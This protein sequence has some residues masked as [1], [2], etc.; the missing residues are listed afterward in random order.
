MLDLPLVRHAHTPILGRM[1]E[2]R[3]S[4]TSYDAAY[5][6]L[7]EGLPAVLLTCDGRLSR[8]HGHRATVELLS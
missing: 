8:A 5:V 7:A 1:W 4:M 3:T 2:L 6:A